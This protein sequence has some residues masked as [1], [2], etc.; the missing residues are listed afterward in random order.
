MSQSFDR[1]LAI[2]REAAKRTQGHVF[3]YVL[4]SPMLYL[5]GWRA[6]ASWVDWGHKEFSAAFEV[7]VRGTRINL[8]FLKR[9]ETTTVGD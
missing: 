7:V 3:D 5:T 6:I 8:R 2:R 4:N 1:W 9:R